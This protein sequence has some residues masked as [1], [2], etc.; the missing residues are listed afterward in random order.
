MRMNTQL[1]YATISESARRSSDESIE[2]R[3]V[4][5]PRKLNWAT[6]EW[7]KAT[8]KIMIMIWYG[9]YSKYYGA[10]H[11]GNTIQRLIMFGFSYSICNIHLSPIQLITIHPFTTN[12]THWYHWFCHKSKYPLPGAPLSHT[13]AEI[14]ILTKPS[15]FPLIALVSLLSIYSSQYIKTIPCLLNTPAV[16]TCQYSRLIPLSAPLLSHD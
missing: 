2:D 3:N 5:W 7:S 15:R 9:Q 1:Y 6:W 10:N 11:V 14:L 16:R 13:L 4:R 12:H 8:I